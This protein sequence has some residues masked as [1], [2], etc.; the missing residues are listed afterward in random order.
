[1]MGSTPLCVVRLIFIRSVFTDF[2]AFSAWTSRASAGE[3]V[4]VEVAEGVGDGEGVRVGVG[5]LV[6]EGVN[7]AVGVGLTVRV[8]VR[9]GVRDFVVVSEGLCVVEGWRVEGAREGV[10]AR[11]VNEHDRLTA[12]SKIKSKK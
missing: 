5:V 11:R 12:P 6:F 1:M 4:R 2:I 8:A 3:S 9:V 10:E 7:V